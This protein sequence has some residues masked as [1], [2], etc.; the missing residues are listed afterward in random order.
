MPLDDGFD[1]VGHVAKD[2]A[3]GS[4]LPSTPPDEGGGFDPAKVP[5]CTSPERLPVPNGRGIM[6][7]RAY[8]DEVTYRDSGREL[9]FVKRRSD[10]VTTPSSG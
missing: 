5:D 9:V 1:C 2:G 7:I 10:P 4:V 3:G 8:M 6:L